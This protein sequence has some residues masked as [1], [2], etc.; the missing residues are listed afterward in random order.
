MARGRKP[1]IFETEEQREEREE[2]EKMLLDG[3]CQS[4]EELYEGTIFEFLKREVEK[5]EKLEE[6]EEEI[7]EFGGIVQPGH[8]EYRGQDYKD[9]PED[10]TGKKRKREEE[11]KEEEEELKCHSNKIRKLNVDDDDDDGVAYHKRMVGYVKEL[12]DC[13]ERDPYISTEFLKMWND[14]TFEFYRNDVTPILY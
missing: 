14:F 1:F 7:R 2:I 12:G 10:I 8:R 13:Y 3:T 9:T 4:D 6:I 11:E 5:V